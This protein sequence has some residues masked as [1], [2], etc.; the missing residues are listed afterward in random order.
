MPHNTPSPDERRALMLQFVQ[1]FQ[2]NPDR[3]AKYTELSL[4]GGQASCVAWQA[5]S[6]IR[7]AAVTL[8]TRCNLNC[9][10]CHRHEDVMQ[11]YLNRDMDPELARS[12][13]PGLKG[14]SLLH[15]AGLGE[16]LLY[17]QLFEL[18]K[19]ARQ[20]VPA[21][22]I[23][24]NAT[25]L[26]E[27]M[28]RKL[29]ESGVT[30]VEVSIDGFDAETNARCR[31]ASLAKVLEGLNNLSRVTSIPIQINSALSSLNHEALFP[32]VDVLRGV[33]NI[34]CLHTIPLFMTRYMV[35]NGIESV[36]VEQHQ[37]LV[38]HWRARLREFGLDWKLVPDAWNAG[39]D[40]VIALKRH[41]NIC[42][43]V[44]ED[45]FINVYGKLAPCGRLQHLSL[46]DPAAKGLE[47]AW[48]GPEFL[49]WRA[50]QLQGRYGEDCVR[51]CFMV[52]R[53]AAGEAP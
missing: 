1:S 30:Y 4:L 19:A 41:R 28:A 44:Y 39:L 52:N 31:G 7:R 50:R 15:W 43:S 45:P 6:S 11:P 33:K 51:E 16:P 27:A 12:L 25:L 23:T 42:F 38:L 2:D 32:A 13:L 21:L 35:E 22:K 34:V 47:Q 18:S 17:P 36:S 14:I 5:K 10:W 46:D 9:L 29:E 53:A 49:A 3:L 37:A 20:F 40:P 26:T 48:N 8:T 24:T